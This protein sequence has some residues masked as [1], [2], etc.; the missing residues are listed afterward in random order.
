MGLAAGAANWWWL[1]RACRARTDAF[2][3]DQRQRLR[4]GHRALKRVL[5]H[6]DAQAGVVVYWYKRGRRCHWYVVPEGH[7]RAL[8]TTGSSKT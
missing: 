8:G 7:V 5:N 3:A 1:S 6:N 2:L 4:A